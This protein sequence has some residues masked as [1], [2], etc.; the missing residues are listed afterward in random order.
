MGM[1]TEMLNDAESCMARKKYDCA[2]ANAKSALRLDP[3]NGQARALMQRAE[4]S[5]KQALESITIQ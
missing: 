1:V 3:N 2:L 4:V 5:Q